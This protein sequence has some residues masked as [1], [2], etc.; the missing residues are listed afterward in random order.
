MAL[1]E[2]SECGR[3]VSQEALNCPNCGAPTVAGRKQDSIKKR[4]RIQLFG[5]GLAALGLVGAF[6]LG[7]LAFPMV[8]IGVVI[9]IIGLI[10]R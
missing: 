1:V 5:F 8:I 10:K 7:P 9:I 4:G 2:C 3:K 6:A